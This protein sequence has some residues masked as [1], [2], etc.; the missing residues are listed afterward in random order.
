MVLIGH[1]QG[2]LLAKLAVVDS[3][4]KFWDNVSHTPFEDLA[5]SDETRTVIRSSLFVK[6]LPFVTRVVFVATPHHGSDVAGFLVQRLRWLVEWALTLPPSLIRVSG[7]VVTGSEDPF[8]RR[9]LR[10]G[11]PRS[12]DNMSPGHRAIKTLATLPLA[13][14]VTANSIIA[15]KG[16][17]AAAQGGDGFVSYESAHLDEAVSE[18]IVRSDHSVQSHPEAIEEIRRILL[19]HL[20]GAGPA[21]AR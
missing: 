3:G 18:L 4:T 11:L 14:G 13:P 16:T 12:V 7:E 9:Q 21:T 8:L 17:G 20:G 6:P 19:Q 10:Q 1:S 2:G 5:V 15:I